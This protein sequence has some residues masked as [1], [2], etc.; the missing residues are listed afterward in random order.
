MMTAIMTFFFCRPHQT[1]ESV[2]LVFLSASIEPFNMTKVSQSHPRAFPDAPRATRINHFWCA[3]L[4]SRTRSLA[5]FRSCPK[6]DGQLWN[7]TRRKPLILQDRECLCPATPAPFVLDGDRPKQRVAV[8]QVIWRAHLSEVHTDL[9]IDSKS[10][11]L[12][13]TCTCTYTCDVRFAGFES[14]SRKPKEFGQP[15]FKTSRFFVDSC[16]PPVGVC[17]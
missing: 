1:T 10:V 16:K 13:C 12:T 7:R 14:V 8:M 4:R 6:W 11:W 5:F 15:E 17:K 9:P 3:T 2:K